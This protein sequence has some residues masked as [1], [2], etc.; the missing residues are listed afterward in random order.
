MRRAMLVAV[1][2]ALLAGAALA[3]KPAQNVSPSHHPNLAA[4]QRLCMQ[5]FDKISAAQHA[6]EWDMNGHAKR[7]KEL[8]EQASNELKQA[9]LAANAHK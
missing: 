5:A 6:N 1:A 2:V 4:A 3:Q 8:L 9:A 7:A